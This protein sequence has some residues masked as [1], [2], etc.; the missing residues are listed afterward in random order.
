MS[1]REGVKCILQLQ[2]KRKLVA[3]ALRK[4]EK[5]P[6]PKRCPMTHLARS[7]GVEVAFVRRMV[8]KGPRHALRK[9]STRVQFLKARST[10]PKNKFAKMPKTAPIV[11][12]INSKALT[13]HQGHR[14]ARPIRKLENRGSR[15]LLTQRQ[16][17]ATPISQEQQKC[18]SICSRHW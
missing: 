18:L 2:E 15:R 17:E 7:L 11:R 3:E 8:V 4:W 1:L 9:A 14:I 6:K 16:K 13:L 5:R 12:E 10:R